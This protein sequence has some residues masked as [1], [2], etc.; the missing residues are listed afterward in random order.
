MTSGRTA[1]QIARHETVSG[2]RHPT[3]VFSYRSRRLA[4]SSWIRLTKWEYWPPWAAYLP[5]VGWI[6]VLAIKHRSL[7]AFTAANP[8]IPAGG[9]IG[10]SKFAILEGLSHSRDRVARSE[11]ISGSLSEYAKRE[12]VRAFLRR[13]GL[14]LPVVLKP[15]EGQRGSG[16][17]V[18]RSFDE[19]DEYL[20]QSIV[21]TIV[22]EY[23][24]G[25]EFGVFYC[26]KPSEPHGRIISVTDKRLP[27]VVGDGRRSLQQLILEA[28]RSLAMARFHLRRQRA[29]LNDVPAAGETVSLGD[30][31]TH[32]RGALFLDGCSA[33]T[34]DVERAFDAIATA[35]DGFYFGRFDVRARSLEDFKAG[36]FTVIELNGVTSEATH[37]YDPAVGLVEAYRVLFEQWRLA[38]EI[39]AENLQRKAQTTSVRE[40]VGLLLRYRR[41]ARAHLHQR[42][43]PRGRSES[44][45]WPRAPEP[46]RG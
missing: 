14:S 3:K 20:R 26:R 7:V 11:L 9:F 31:G 15:N 32:C 22:Q 30:L 19:L 16:V 8:A 41:D 25:V 35:Y 39:G 17:V 34:P 44:M 12:H 37:I 21:D 18:A 24:P 28:P 1:L 29:R 38:F 40:L 6:G 4:A 27:V 46:K 5:L 42:P 10:E 36:R 43:A 2:R 13:E 23:V 45:R 33:L